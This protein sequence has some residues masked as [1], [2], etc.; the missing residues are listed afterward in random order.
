[1]IN[2][3]IFKLNGDSRLYRFKGTGAPVNP[4][5]EW[6]SPLPSSLNEHDATVLKEK[7]TPDPDNSGQFIRSIV[8]DQGK[9]NQRDLKNNNDL[10]KGNKDRQDLADAANRL[11]ALRKQDFTSEAVQRDAILDIIDILFRGEKRT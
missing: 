3:L 8:I 6:T 9:K 7:L 10:I 11:L 5:I 4:N 1:M 2:E